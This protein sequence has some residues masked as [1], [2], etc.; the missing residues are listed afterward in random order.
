M[1]KLTQK[2]DYCEQ[3]ITEVLGAGFEEPRR[4]FKLG[5]KEACLNCH[6]KAQKLMEV[7]K[8]YKDH[9]CNK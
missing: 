2:C 6:E 5:T 1:K 3:E 4:L 9:D 8:N 7:S